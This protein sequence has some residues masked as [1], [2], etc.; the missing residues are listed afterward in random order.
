MTW[1]VPQPSKIVLC[2]EAVNKVTVEVWVV[3]DFERRDQ[4]SKT[5]TSI[6]FWR[7]HRSNTSISCSNSNQILSFDELGC[8]AVRVIWI[9]LQYISNNSSWSD[10][11]RAQDRYTFICIGI[12]SG[13]RNADHNTFCHSRESAQTPMRRDLPSQAMPESFIGTVGSRPW[14]TA[15]L[16]SAVRFSASLAN[17]ASFLAISAPIWRFLRPRSGRL[18]VVRREVEKRF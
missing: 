9:D 10:I 8:S 14:V 11:H 5:L 1:A 2:G 15:W 13:F 3:I 12:S 4:H 7:Y 18:L 6:Q 16:I 17:N